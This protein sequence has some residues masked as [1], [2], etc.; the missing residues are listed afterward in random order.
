MAASSSKIAA[1]TDFSSLTCGK[2]LLGQDKDCRSGKT[3]EVADV[4]GN[5]KMQ[6]GVTCKESKNYV[7]KPL[8]GVHK[9][10]T[11][12]TENMHM[13]RT[14]A[15]SSDEIIAMCSDFNGT[16]CNQNV[17]SSFHYASNVHANFTVEE[18][19][20]VADPLQAAKY[21]CQRSPQNN[22]G[23]C[24][25]RSLLASEDDIEEFLKEFSECSEK[26]TNMYDNLDCNSMNIMKHILED[27]KRGGKVLPGNKGNKL[28]TNSPFLHESIGN[29][30]VKEHGEEGGMLNGP[31]SVIEPEQPYIS[32]LLSLSLGCANSSNYGLSLSPSDA[33]SNLSLSLGDRQSLSP[34]PGSSYCKRGGKYLSKI[35]DSSFSKKDKLPI[36]S[37]IGSPYIARSQKSQGQITESSFSEENEQ[38]GNSDISSPYSERGCNPLGQ[39]NLSLSKKSEQLTRGTIGLSY[40]ERVRKSVS[41][42]ARDIFPLSCDFI[43]SLPMQAEAGNN[44]DCVLSQSKR[45]VQSIREDITSRELSQQDTIQSPQKSML[46]SLETAPEGSDKECVRSTK[47]VIRSNRKSRCSKKENIGCTIVAKERKKRKRNTS[48]DLTSDSRTMAMRGLTEANGK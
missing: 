37:N 12:D 28:A 13:E 26:E 34:Q 36:G 11:N 47:G 25:D 10:D 31:Y 9:R 18:S 8:G 20:N 6:A 14:C 45:M 42:R 5:R 7:Y 3:E 48:M 27:Q 23:Y 19:D 4:T 29:C 2:K 30:G 32:S 43:A 17:P 21:I 35:K 38:S 22:T 1:S 40:S 41:P 33:V 16:K 46:F 44:S 24:S 39:I 15:S